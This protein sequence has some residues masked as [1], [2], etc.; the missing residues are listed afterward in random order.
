MNM[1]NSLSDTSP[2][3]QTLNQIIPFPGN[4]KRSD[5]KVNPY[6]NDDYHKASEYL[7]L[8]LKLLS[9]YQIPPSPLNFRIGYDYVVG[10]SEELNTTLDEIIEQTEGNPA[11]NLWEIYRRF[12]VQEDKA[13]D[14][15]RQELRRII[16]NMQDEFT[17][18]GEN[19]SSYT[20]TLN[21]FAKILDT[22]KS[23]ETMSVEVQKVI[24]DTHSMESSQE[25]VESQIS[26]I[27]LEVESLRKELEQVKEESL[28]DALTGI[29]N[30][31]A[32]DATLEQ[33]IQSAHKQSAPFCLLMLDIDHFKQFNDTY[34]HL[35][36]DK[37]LRFVAST[38][39]R[40]LKGQDIAARFGGEEFAMILPQ[41][42]LTGGAEA[43]S[44]QIRQAISSG[45]LKDKGNGQSYGRITV[46]I[47]IAQ[48][49]MNELPND[50]IGR[51]D[52]ALYLAKERG[53]NRVEMAT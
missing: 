50:L 8:T 49:R 35:V 30:R 44:E 27:M 6:S 45:D 32:F 53:R 40:C 12:F 2:N 37:V 14:K 15:M 9:K 33:T 31:K 16:V 1:E 26:S 21:R 48:F 34:G 36:G 10:K 43:I 52:R 51:A 23:P 5:L 11:E 28:T 29:L 24:D 22:Q 17:H 42:A 46:S 47:G 4:K 3:G 19:L 39:K 20:K 41:T 18:S 38:L 25:R 13:L 7:R